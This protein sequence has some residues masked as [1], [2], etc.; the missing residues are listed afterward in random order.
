MSLGITVWVGAISYVIYLW[1]WPLIVLIPFLTDAPL[2]AVQKIAIGAASVGS[3]Y[4][5]TR[6]IEDPVKTGSYMRRPVRAFAFAG[7]RALVFLGIGIPAQ[8]KLARAETREQ[9]RQNEP[10]NDPCLGPGALDKNNDCGSPMGSGEFFVSPEVAA[11]Q[12]QEMVLKEC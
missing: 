2:V 6:F 4:L 5:S 3:A 9:A 10:F 7:V 1:H 11:I 12:N 8:Q